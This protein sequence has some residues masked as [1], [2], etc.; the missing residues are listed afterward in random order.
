M[1]IEMN[2]AQPIWLDVWTVCTT[3][4]SLAKSLVVNLAVLTDG[5]YFQSAQT[6][7]LNLDYW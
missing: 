1:K 5:S 3:I 2:F 6:K 7:H 4:E